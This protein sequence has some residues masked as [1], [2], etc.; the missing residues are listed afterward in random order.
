MS[1]PELLS[2]HIQALKELQRV[3]WRQ[4]AD[5]ALTTF[6]RRELRNELKQSE[7][8]LRIYLDLMSDHCRSR[9]T[10]VEDDA[11]RGMHQFEFRVLAGN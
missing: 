10:P 1:E 4:L 3:A 2:Q 9:V 6:E 7:A 5:S 11:A 8:Q